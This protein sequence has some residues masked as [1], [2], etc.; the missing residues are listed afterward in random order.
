MIYDNIKNIE[1]YQGLSG[2]IYDGL[3]YL[4]SIDDSIENGVHQIT[5]NVKAIVSEYETKEANP[6]GFEAH[7]EYLDIQYLVSGKEIIK[8]IPID[9]LVVVRDY[10]EANDYLLFSDNV[11]NTL[12]FLLG[13]G[14]FTLLY[15]DDAHEPQLCDGKPMPVKKVVIKIKIRK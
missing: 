5:D 6:N 4:T 15:P 1:R 11:N 13:E 14:Y 9:D 10:D 8:C 7:R 12:D 2:D 3:R